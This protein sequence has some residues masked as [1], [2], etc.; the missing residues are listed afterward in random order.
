[1]GGPWGMGSLEGNTKREWGS[2]ILR[3]NVSTSVV[4]WCLSILLLDSEKIHA[5]KFTDDINTTVPVGK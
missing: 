4:S 3:N 5:F 1:M 2:H